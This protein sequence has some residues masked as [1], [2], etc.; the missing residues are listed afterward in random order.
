MEKIFRFEFLQR[1]CNLN[2]EG[3]KIFILRIKNFSFRP[4]Q[5][6]FLG[7]F[8][9]KSQLSLAPLAP[10]AIYTVS[11]YVSLGVERGTFDQGI[12]YNLA[13]KV[14]SDNCY[15]IASSWRPDLPQTVQNLFC[16]SWAILAAMTLTKNNLFHAV[17]LEASR[18]SLEKL[19]NN[20][21][22]IVA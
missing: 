15:H 13:R 21:V 5:T 12:T 19:C 9:L 8:V 17:A 20:T 1:V 2:G 7:V 10:L 16:E 4:I 18:F 3:S 14:L 22:G 11:S 6:N